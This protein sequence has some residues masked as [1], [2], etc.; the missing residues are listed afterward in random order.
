MDISGLSSTVSTSIVHTLNQLGSLELVV[1]ILLGVAS[2]GHLLS[3]LR[4]LQ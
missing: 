2:R 4:V 1:T 3:T